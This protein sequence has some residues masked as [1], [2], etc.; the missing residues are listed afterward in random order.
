MALYYGVGSICCLLWENKSN[1]L[2][3][4]RYIYTHIYI[5]IYIY[6]YCFLVATM[7]ISRYTQG[8]IYT[9]IF[10]WIII[11]TCMSIFFW[12][13][14]YYFT[15]SSDSTIIA[16]DIG[17]R[18]GVS[19]QLR[20][21]TGPVSCFEFLSETNELMSYGVDKKLIM[22]DMKIQRVEV[23]APLPLLLLLHPPPPPT[24]SP[25]LS[26]SPPTPPPPSSPVLSVFL[27]SSSL[28]SHL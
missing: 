17:G 1:M 27:L 9:C 26:L 6:I 7:I 13:I 11:Y 28:F 5:Y 14:I 21:H 16:W 3:S 4:G 23:N 20:G 18:K 8:I 24:P 25:P 10:F 22:W 15:I 2:F 19:Y 12:I